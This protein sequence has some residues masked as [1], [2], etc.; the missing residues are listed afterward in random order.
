MEGSRDR[1]RACADELCVRSTIPRPNQ[2]L[3]SSSARSRISR[4]EN[5][6]QPKVDVD[7]GK[8]GYSVLYRETISDVLC[9]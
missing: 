6:F 1:G 3:P 7:R 5:S 4:D 9:V 2:T 8:L